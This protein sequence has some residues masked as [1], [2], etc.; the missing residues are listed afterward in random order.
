MLP[1]PREKTCPDLTP[2]V[3]FQVLDQ[4][5]GW[6]CEVWFS[7]I[8]FCL[9]TGEDITAFQNGKG[10]GDLLGG[11]STSPAPEF[12]R[13][14]TPSHLGCEHDHDAIHGPV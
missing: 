14:A 2:P 5:A 8:Y 12:L 1:T 4:Q 6:F 10:G 11:G 7:L 13:K 9:N 3:P